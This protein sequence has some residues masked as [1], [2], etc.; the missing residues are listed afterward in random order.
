MKTTGVFLSYAAHDRA[1]CKRL[2]GDFG[3]AAQ[4]DTKYNFSLWSMDNNLLAGD[5]FEDEIRAALDQSE[6]GVFAVSHAMLASKFIQTIELHHFLEAGKLVVPVL[7]TQISSF[8]DL[9]GLR[10]THVF[11]WGKPYEAQRSRA[12]RRNWATSLAEEVH[13]VLDKRPVS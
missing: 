9:Q 4:A 1:L 10:D 3:A 5:N 12:A 11:C 6:V 13:R 7:L 8:A 2:W